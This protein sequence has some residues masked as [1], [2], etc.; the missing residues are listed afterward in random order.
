MLSEIPNKLISYESKKFI[1][2]RSGSFW[3]SIDLT[4]IVGKYNAISPWIINFKSSKVASV[5][6]SKSI[7]FKLA[8]KLGLNTLSPLFVNK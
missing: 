1:S 3:N 8:P 7:D 2:L 5:I 4:L 6:F